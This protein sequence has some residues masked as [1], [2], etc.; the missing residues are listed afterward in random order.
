MYFRKKLSVCLPDFFWKC[1]RT[2]LR[3][4]DLV[5]FTIYLL[6]NLKWFA[7][8]KFNGMTFNHDHV[9]TTSA[10]R[11][12]ALS[13]SFLFLC[14]WKVWLRQNRLEIWRLSLTR[15]DFDVV[16]DYFHPDAFA[17]NG[18]NWECKKTWG[19]RRLYV[20]IKATTFYPAPMACSPRVIRLDFFP[21]LF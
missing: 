10:K 11:I 2:W 20:W 21:W 5:G 12:V 8:F 7:V 4:N 6:L 15:D 18:E 17:E 19:F 14:W 16:H 9:Q 3:S 1:R 13:H